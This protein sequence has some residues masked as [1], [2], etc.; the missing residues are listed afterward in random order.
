MSIER[1]STLNYCG[2]CSKGERASEL[3]VPDLNNS[4]A[5]ARICLCCTLPERKCRGSE[6]CERYRT[7]MK[8]IKGSRKR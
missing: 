4:D 6:K 1:A 5:E 8:V 3:Y 7:A 2:L